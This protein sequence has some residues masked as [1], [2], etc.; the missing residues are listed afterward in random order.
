MGG[1][2]VVEWALAAPSGDPHSDKPIPGNHPGS[3]LPHT[4]AVP[5][6]VS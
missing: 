6:H 5:L 2:P 4:G 1:Q 3:A